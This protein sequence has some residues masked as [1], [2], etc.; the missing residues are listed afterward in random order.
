[1]KTILETE[2][3][4]LRPFNIDDATALYA[5]GSHPEVI[6]YAGNTP[7][8]SVDAAREMLANVIFQDYAVRG[9]GR[10]ACVWKE[11]GNVIGFSGVKYIAD[12][13]DSELGYRFMPEYWGKGLATESAV[14]SI[15]F[16]RDTLG[17]KR[18]IGLVHPDNH[19]SAKVM[20]KM[21]FDLERKQ[22]FALVQDVDVDL[23]SRTL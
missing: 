23:Y 6:R 16:A 5:M 7:M 1:M 9:Y 10:F 12:L 11:T 22:S 14:A 8:A 21:G 17:L 4:I 20:L 15:D 19:N 18:L 3:L 2:R 13:D